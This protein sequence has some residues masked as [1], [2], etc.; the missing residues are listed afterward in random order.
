MKQTASKFLLTLFIFVISACGTVAPATPAA[1][2]VPT[3][4]PT[5]LPATA[6]PLPTKQ[7]PQQQGSQCTYTIGGIDF[8]VALNSIAVFSDGAKLD[9]VECNPEG[10]LVAHL[11]SINQVADSMKIVFAADGHMCPP[12]QNG[13]PINLVNSS[14]MGCNYTN[15]IAY[16]AADTT[17]DIGGYSEFATNDTV[18]FTVDR[19]PAALITRT[20]DKLSIRVVFTGDS[21]STEIVYPKPDQILVY[22]KYDALPVQVN[23]TKKQVLQFDSF[24]CG[25]HFY[26]RDGVDRTKQSS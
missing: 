24:V 9:Y 21:Y 1:T 18:V 6:T 8:P 10:I 4:Q 20:D 13:Q 15:G 12:R 5:A 17:C 16:I 14:P 23:A 25:T 22:T 2:K 7:S 11:Q 19:K 3:V 26:L